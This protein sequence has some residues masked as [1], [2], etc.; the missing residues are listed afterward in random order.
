MT[1][2]TET[3]KPKFRTWYDFKLTPELME[4]GG[5]QSMTIPGES[6]TIQEILSKFASGADLALSKNPIF[7]DPDDFDDLDDFRRPDYDLADTVEAEIEIKK[8][9]ALRKQKNKQ[10][11]D[12]TK[13]DDSLATAKPDA[14][15]S[16]KAKVEPAAGF[17]E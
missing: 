12:T 4:A 8:Y 13:P 14:T 3:N 15:T 11:S 16:Q 9:Q 10:P 6:Y 17:E 1:K 5:G 2:I 7:T